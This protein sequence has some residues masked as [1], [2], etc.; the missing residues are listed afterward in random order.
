MLEIGLNIS[1]C[2][3]REDGLDVKG[4]A[5]DRGCNDLIDDLVVILSSANVLARKTYTVC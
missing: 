3:L 4:S 5:G 2:L 1:C